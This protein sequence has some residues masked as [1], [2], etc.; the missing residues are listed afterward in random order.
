MVYS[1]LYSEGWVDQSLIQTWV[2]LLM[3]IWELEFIFC[4]SQH[5]PLSWGRQWS[6][7]VSLFNVGW[8]DKTIPSFV[9]PLKKRRQRRYFWIISYINIKYAALGWKL[10]TI[11]IRL[12]YLGFMCHIQTSNDHV[13]ISIRKHIFN[14]DSPVDI[15]VIL[16]DCMY[17]IENSRDEKMN[18]ELKQQVD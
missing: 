10:R 6:R 9:K 1:F 14:N 2:P 7:R 17:C 5:A 13:F 4:E 11:W 15:P 3:W 18:A 8:V 12:S 16:I